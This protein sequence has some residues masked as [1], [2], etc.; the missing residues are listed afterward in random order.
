MRLMRGDLGRSFRKSSLLAPGGHNFLGLMLSER[1][2]VKEEATKQ[3]GKQEALAQTQA[4]GSQGGVVPGGGG[5]VLRRCWRGMRG[6]GGEL[7]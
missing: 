1:P 2:C 4:L 3:A 7:A 5:D 6:V